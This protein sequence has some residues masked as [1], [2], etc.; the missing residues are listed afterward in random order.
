MFS[1]DRCWPWSSSAFTGNRLNQGPRKKVP[2]SRDIW[3]VLG[4]RHGGVNKLLFIY[5]SVILFVVMALCAYVG[6]TNRENK[7]RGITFHRY[8]RVVFGLL[9]LP[10]RSSFVGR[11]QCAD[12]VCSTSR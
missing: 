3:R 2:Q 10:Y 6:C 7:E 12:V 4:R 9:L 8:D 11:L 5:L 1:A